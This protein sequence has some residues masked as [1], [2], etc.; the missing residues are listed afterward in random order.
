MHL[1]AR[2]PHNG[3]RVTSSPEPLQ[4]FSRE[5][6]S[7]ASLRS[8]STSFHNQYLRLAS[9]VEDWFERGLGFGRWTIRQRLVTLV[10]TLA[11]PLNLLIVA[12]IWQLAQA[13]GE[14]QRTALLYTARSV[15]GAVDAHIGKYIGLAQSLANSVRSCAMIFEALRR[16]LNA[17]FLR[18]QTRGSSLP[19]LKVGSCTTQP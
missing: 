14:S 12:A 1:R 15:A 19:T 6:A 11:L 17:P 8:F 7:S 9:T 3:P 5:P 2:Y 16:R 4:P 10:L 18:V 13:A